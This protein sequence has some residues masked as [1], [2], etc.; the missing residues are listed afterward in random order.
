MSPPPPPRPAGP[1]PAGTLVNS[2]YTV[3]EVLGRGANAI[4]YLATDNTT[5][6][7]VSGADLTAATGTVSRTHTCEAPVGGGGGGGGG[8]GQRRGMIC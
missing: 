7:K 6:N 5:G 1:V 3:Q 2:R 8:R 4:T